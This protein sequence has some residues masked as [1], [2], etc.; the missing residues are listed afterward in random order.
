MNHS[1]QTVIVGRFAEGRKG[2]VQRPPAIMKRKLLVCMLIAATLSALAC[3]ALAEVDPI[4]CNMEVT[5]QNLTGPGPVSITISISNSG[6]TDMK[7]P[8]I[9]YNPINQLVKDFGDNGAA[10]LKA[11]ETKTWTGNWDVNQRTLENGSVVFFVKYTLYHDNGSSYSQSQ[12]IRGKIAYQAADAGIDV[13]RTI[14][15]GTA[16]EGQTVTVKYDIINTGTVSLQNVTVQEHSNINKTAQKI[17]ELKAGET[18]QV[19]FPVTM[20]KKNLISEAVIAYQIAGSSGKETVKVEAATIV[21]G[22]PAM[23]AKL[24]SSA[25]GVTTNGKVTLTLELTN[26]GNVDYSDLRVTD[27]TLGEVFSN[28]SLAKNGT[29]K[30]EKEI[31]LTKTTDYQFTITAID[32][33]GTEV[34]LATDSLTLTAV[35]PNQSLHLTVVANPDRTE[36]YEQPGRV[37]FSVVITNDSQMDAK[38]VDILHGDT[39]IY[40]FSSIA[41]GQTRSLT[42]DAALSMPGKYQFTASAKDALD[43]SL[44]FKSNEM[45]IAFSVPTPAPETPTPVPD[46]TAEPVFIPMTMPPIR[47]QSIGT[48]PKIIRSVLFPVL[49]ICGLLLIACMV[50]LVIATKRRA[51]QKKASEAAYD[52]LE[53]AKR[54]DY[55]TPAESEE[56]DAAVNIGKEKLSPDKQTASKAPVMRAGG[57]DHEKTKVPLDDVE[58]PHMKYVR[59]AYDRKAIPEMKRQTPPTIYDDD[60]YGGHDVFDKK[61]QEGV[62]YEESYEDAYGAGDSYP[63]SQEGDDQDQDGYADSPQHNGSGR[64]YAEEYNDLYQEGYG[65][66]S[67]EDQGGEEETLHTD[68]R[69]SDSFDPEP[70]SFHNSFDEGVSPD[71]GKEPPKRRATSRSARETKGKELGL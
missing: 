37:R 66:Y 69:V 27:P 13:K 40:T 68:D 10:L 34:S 29:L 39:K 53:R 33:T 15:P 6:D 24:T 63:Y 7:D 38:N 51:E 43:N 62:L 12:P 17:A 36:V 48:I 52:H 20:G 21:Y 45:Q 18:A 42:R 2:A 28:Q 67:K 1:L 41:A 65:D 8:V 64:G 54:R 30:L 23:T 44:T 32:N 49:I 5:P 60:L 56:Q 11:G 19:K 71:T 35:E 50:V 16:R 57:L 46:P 25:K 22:D 31:T 26:K 70:T 9:L 58:L 47:D 3:L 55:V 14:S 59:D 4:V 61:E